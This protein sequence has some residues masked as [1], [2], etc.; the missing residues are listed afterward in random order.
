MGV[1][2]LRRA[3]LADVPGLARLR[4]EG[5]AGGASADRMTR[6]LAGE[7]HPQQALLP[8][9]MWV[10]LQGDAPIGYV[11]GHLTRRFGCDGELQ[12]IYVVPEH[13]RTQ[14][15]SQL[16]GRLA[17]WFV[18]H[19]ARYVCVDVGDDA[20]RPFYRRHRAVDLNKH[21]MVW[22]DIAVVFEQ[23]GII[24][25]ESDLNETV[26]RLLLDVAATV[27]APHTAIVVELA[28]N[29]RGLNLDDRSSKC[30]DDVQQY[31]HDTFVD[32][33]WP[34]C[35]R[36]P[37]HPLEFSEGFWCCPRDH[38]RMTK[39]GELSTRPSIRG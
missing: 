25:P 13:R 4:Q 8:R 20:A 10:A 22:N 34:A 14:V 7:H 32:T 18:D 35:P 29:A 15:G 21:W 38:S 17:Q 3:D 16:L 19:H 36:H 26:R 28:D 30:V 24:A 31:F 23:A 5:E 6:Y 11:A 33:T 27:G 12:W 37:N 9:A 1:V 39:L 2:R